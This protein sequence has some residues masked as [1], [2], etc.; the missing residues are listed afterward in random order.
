[1]KNKSALFALS[2]VACAGPG[3]GI[4]GGQVQPSGQY[5]IEALVKDQT[6][7]VYLLD[8]SDKVLP[9]PAS[10]KAV[11]EARQ[12][13]HELAL[14]T[15]GEAAAAKM[16]DGIKSGDDLVVLLSVVLDGQTQELRFAFAGRKRGAAASGGGSFSGGGAAG[17][18]SQRA[19]VERPQVER[20]VRERA[21]RG[22]GGGHCG[23]SSAPRL[24]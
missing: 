12:S 20:P 4:H 7:F 18:V 5:R 1:M 10:A 15:Q 14:A 13:R 16:P 9:P 2:L 17:G 21:T 19:T 6:L 11:V 22:G 8:G 23:G 3:A 24:W